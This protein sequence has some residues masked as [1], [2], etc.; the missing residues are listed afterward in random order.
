MLK[1][2]SDRFLK[3]SPRLFLVIGVLLVI[4]TYYQ[5]IFQEASYYYN[6][7]IGK[8]FKVAVVRNVSSI[9]PELVSKINTDPTATTI[10]PV[11]TN[12]GIVIEKINVNAPIVKDV[13]I[14]DTKSYLES[15]KLG[16]A[17]ASFSGYP[18]EQN[19]N[20]YL[21]AHSS[22][23]FWELGKYSSVFNLIYKL[24]IKDQVNIFY[25]GKRYIYEVENK[26]L[27][28]DFKVDDTVY[29][30]FGPT[31]TLQTCYPTGTSLYRLIVRAT[32]VGVYDYS[33]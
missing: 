2:L 33:N 24:N 25:E 11:D 10:K 6:Y 5:T 23:N 16:V 18:N 20:V 32:L 26:L 27:V 17:H 1:N 12:F 14:I 30:Y 7:F 8:H 22:N 31:L 29:E 19:S 13:P 21:F 4:L 9:K 15:L 3:N 28:N